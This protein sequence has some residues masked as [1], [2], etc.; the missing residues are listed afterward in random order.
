MDGNGP[1]CFLVSR[2]S[3]DVCTCLVG[4]CKLKYAYA[5]VPRG[6][7]DPMQ[8]SRSHRTVQAR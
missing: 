3:V 7:G 6:Q 5:F 2:V 8:G 4:G 1:S